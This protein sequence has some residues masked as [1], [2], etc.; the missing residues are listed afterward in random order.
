MQEKVFVAETFY[1]VCKSAR[2]RSQAF[3]LALP[4]FPSLGVPDC[5]KNAVSK[6][7]LLLFAMRLCGPS[8]WS[9]N[10]RVTKRVSDKCGARNGFQCSD[11][12][13]P[14]GAEGV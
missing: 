5:T 12:D 1:L 8:A 6:I 3:V 11:R 13:D 2:S 9:E 10:T 14:D 4:F 7:A